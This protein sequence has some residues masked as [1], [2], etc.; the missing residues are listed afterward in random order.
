MRSMF[1]HPSSDNHGMSYAN[2]HPRARALNWSI[3]VVCLFVLALALAGGGCSR[4]PPALIPNKD[5]SL[6]K[7][8]REFAQ[9]AAKRHP[10]KADAPKAGTAV[11]R[12]QVGYSMDQVEVVN[13]SDETW[14]DVEVWVNQRYVVHVPQ[15]KPHELKVLNF[16]ML[17]NEKKEAFPMFNTSDA[18]RVETVEVLWAGQMYNVPVALAD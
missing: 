16:R 4:T 1:L 17:Y 9:D 10:Y 13:L 15:M 18:K 12:A 7:S 6:R 11:A 2:H 14:E 5:K 3:F 8:S